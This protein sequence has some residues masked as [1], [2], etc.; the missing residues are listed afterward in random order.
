VLVFDNFFPFCA[1]VTKFERQ[2]SV[3]TY[4][5]ASFLFFFHANIQT[6]DP[7]VPCWFMTRCCVSFLNDK[8]FFGG[9]VQTEQQI[10]MVT[11]LLFSCLMS[12]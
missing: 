11:K 12:M 6:A 9:C 1:G 7:V 5:N 4:D 2:N 3:V 8:S 10:L